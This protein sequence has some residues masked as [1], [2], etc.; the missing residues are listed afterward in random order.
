MM[1][2]PLIGMK[3]EYL[4]RGSY[5]LFYVDYAVLVP[6][7]CYPASV[8]NAPHVGEC[9]AQLIERI[10]ETGQSDIHLIGFSLGAQ[11]SNYVANKLKPDFI[12]PRISGLDPALPLFA[13]VGIDSKLDATDADFVDVIHTNALVQGKIERCG[14]VDFYL[15]GGVYQPGCTGFIINPFACSH[16]RAPL[17]FMESIQS[18]IGFWG[19]R[20]QS[21]L[22]YLLSLCPPIFDMQTMAGE[23]CRSSSRGMYFIKTSDISPYAIGRLSEE[24]ISITE[25]QQTLPMILSKVKN[26]DPFQQEIDSFG[27]LEGNFN[28][29]QYSTAN[30]DMDEF[31]YFNHRGSNKITHAFIEKL[32]NNHQNEAD[33]L[34]QIDKPNLIKKRVTSRRKKPSIRTNSKTSE[35]KFYSED[36]VVEKFM[37]EMLN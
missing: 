9:I 19:W 23:D 21:Y 35:R 20:C 33:I 6:S 29:L 11:V 32:R 25:K 2:T 5:N 28:N 26:A 15:N 12:I 31:P 22:Y 18:E 30:Q 17:Y 16:H 34:K 36:S 3:N 24:I 4:Q 1:L 7:P 37:D 10:L 13:H 14:H 8:N 27:K